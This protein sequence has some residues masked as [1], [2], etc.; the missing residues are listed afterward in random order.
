MQFDLTKYAKQGAWRALGVQRYLCCACFSAVVSWSQATQQFTGHVAD[1]TGAVIPD[2]QVIVHNKAT[3]VDA[4][5]V[6]TNSG[7]YTV[8]YT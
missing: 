7:A 5:T 8:T 4:K 3:G 2:A 1:H 6:T